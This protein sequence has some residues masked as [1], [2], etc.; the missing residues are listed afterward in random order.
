MHADKNI[1]IPPEL[2][3][4]TSPPNVAQSL[5]KIA[6]ERTAGRRASRIASLAGAEPTGIYS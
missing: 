6:I 5:V 3:P 4:L 1:E 2:Q